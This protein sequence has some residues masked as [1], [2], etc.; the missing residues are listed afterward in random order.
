M[1]SQLTEVISATNKDIPMAF[2]PNA[3][4]PKGFYFIFLYSYIF[5]KLSE[6]YVLFYSF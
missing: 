1:P 5:V 6:Y 3:R 4:F 2:V